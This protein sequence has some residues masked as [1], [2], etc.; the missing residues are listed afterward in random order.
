NPF[1]EFVCLVA[2]GIF[3]T[4]IER[5]FGPVVGI[6]II[7]LAGAGGAA[8]S[9]AGHWYPTLG[10]NGIALGLLTAWLVDDRLA[11]RRGDDRDNDLL[12]VWVFAALLLL[13]PVAERDASFFAGIGGAGVGAVLGAMVSPFKP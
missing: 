2:I 8:L 11:H 12:G 9:V 4:L 10:G 13:L 1:Y 5:R 3:G 6:A 7:V